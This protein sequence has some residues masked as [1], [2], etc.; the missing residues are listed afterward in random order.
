MQQLH[1]TRTRATL[2]WRGDVDSD[3]HP[4]T[5]PSNR[6]HLSNRE[7]NLNALE[8]KLATALLITLSCS[9]LPFPNQKI[10]QSVLIIV[11]HHE[12]HHSSHLVIGDSQHPLPHRCIQPT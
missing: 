2:G 3:P 1:K 9:S 7:R 5:T 4:F 11:S 6:F 8:I 12:L 10:H